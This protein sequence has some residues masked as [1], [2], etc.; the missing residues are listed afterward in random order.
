MGYAACQFCVCDE[1]GGLVVLERLF[2]CG[3]VQTFR[4]DKETDGEAMKPPEEDRRRRIDTLVYGKHSTDT[5]F[6]INNE[7]YYLRV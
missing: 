6:N 7:L 1:T 4:P 3:L 5:T 2:V